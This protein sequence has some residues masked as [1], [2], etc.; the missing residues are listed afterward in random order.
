LFL[1]G[2]VTLTPKPSLRRAV[3]PLVSLFTRAPRAESNVF[4]FVFVF[5]HGD[6]RQ[7]VVAISTEHNSPR[8][9]SH[10]LNCIRASAAL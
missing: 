1:D 7:G 2:D 4:V 10:L 3:F 9:Q 8:A 6:I 5:V